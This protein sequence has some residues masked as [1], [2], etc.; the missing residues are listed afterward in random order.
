MNGAL[1][2]KTLRDA[3]AAVGGVAVALFAVAA[4]RVGLYPLYRDQLTDA[5]LPE[6]MR[7]FFGDISSIAT[8]EG[9]Y[10]SSYFALAPLLA[11]IVGLIAGSAAVAGEEAAG[12]LDLLLAQ[13]VRRTRLLLEKAAGIGLGVA[14]GVLASLLGFLI[15]VPW[16]ETEVRPGPATVAHL[17]M[18]HQALLF[19][20]VAIAG[21]AWL[22][23][24][25]Q[26]GLVAA[27]LMIATWVAAGLGASIESLA[28]L[29]DI[30]PFGWV[31]YEAVL[32]GAWEWQPAAGD[33]LLTAALL[34]LACWG[35]ERRD[36][37]A[38]PRERTGWRGFAA[39]LRRE[40]A[41]EKPPLAQ[42]LPR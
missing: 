30:S 25:A 5:L 6:S 36:I 38:G 7:R 27:G 33:V 42:D 4:L 23:S 16:P 28:V 3:K 40:G 41:S 24:R 17:E 34:A 12:T 8:P 39:R 18:A 26:A 10:A 31:E 2:W 20:A 9:Y 15:F 13:P 37:V 29:R 35:F 22:P 19:S 32:R 11:A 14:V 1:W 21:S